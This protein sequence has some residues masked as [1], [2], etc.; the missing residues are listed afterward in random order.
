[1]SIL[2]V[3]ACVWVL[4]GAWRGYKRG[5][6]RVLAGVLSLLLGYVACFLWGWPLA[7]SLSGKVTPF[8]QWPIAAG[9]IFLVVALVV[10]LLFWPLAKRYKQSA[11]TAWLGV[12]GNS[13]MATVMLMAALWGAGLVAGAIP[14]P[15]IKSVLQQIGYSAE[16]PLVRISNA[17][18]SRFIGVGLR[19]VGASD[20]QVKAGVVLAQTPAAGVMNLQAVSGSNETKALLHSEPLKQAIANGDVE[21]LIQHPDFVAFSQQPGMESMIALV[22]RDNGE[23]QAQALATTMVDVF[24]RVEHI[25]Q[26]DE[27]RKVLEDPEIQAIMQ[28]GDTA[29]LMTQPKMQ[30]LL[31][32]I[33]GGSMA[34][35]SEK[36]TARAPVNELAEQ[37]K[38]EQ[39]AE[40][41]GP[42]HEV[43]FKWKNANGQTHFSTWDRIPKAYREGAELINL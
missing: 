19:L 32:A 24:Q 2:A 7:Q 28:S 21:Q 6:V 1:M 22:P 15:N 18:M 12:A 16:H 10:N 41:S 40:P 14:S 37:V 36:P 5:A 9:G 30:P 27:T 25:K 26:S 23:S 43:M 34:Q 35:E 11:A 42:A 4:W 33:M 29:R 39:P 31:A 17:V 13:A 8:L 38:T 20:E 3:I